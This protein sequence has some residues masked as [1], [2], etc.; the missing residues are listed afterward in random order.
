GS[1]IQKEKKLNMGV[2]NETDTRPIPTC[3][4]LYL[5]IHKYSESNLDLLLSEP[6]YPE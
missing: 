1:E 6:D 4:R 3:P 5:R 2:V